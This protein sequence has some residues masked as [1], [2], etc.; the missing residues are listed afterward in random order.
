M[1]VDARTNGH[2]GVRFDPTVNLGHIGSMTIALCTMAGMF[3]MV[4]AYD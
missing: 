2:R 4:S 1:T 3:T